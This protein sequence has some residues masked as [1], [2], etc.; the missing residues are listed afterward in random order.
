MREEDGERGRRSEG[1]EGRGSHHSFNDSS[2]LTSRGSDCT[3]LDDD[4]T[5]SSERE[6]EKGEGTL[7]H[8]SKSCDKDS[9]KTRSLFL[10]EKD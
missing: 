5:V 3:L 8:H 2:S 1:Y 10:L 9:Q 6:V 4:E 7:Q